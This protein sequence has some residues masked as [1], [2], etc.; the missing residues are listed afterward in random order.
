MTRQEPIEIL[1]GMEGADLVQDTL[2]FKTLSFD[3]TA[4]LTGEFVEKQ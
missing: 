3:E 2:L 1:E 4:Q